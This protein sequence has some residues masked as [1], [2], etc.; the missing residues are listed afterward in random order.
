MVKRLPSVRRQSR[1]D[2]GNAWVHLLVD[3][4][5][6]Q[7][8]ADKIDCGPCTSKSSD[9]RTVIVSFYNL[10]PTF[11]TTLRLPKNLRFAVS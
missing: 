4:S 5:E 6:V 2:G 11:T 1:C 7:R 3:A 8:V 9:T 10:I